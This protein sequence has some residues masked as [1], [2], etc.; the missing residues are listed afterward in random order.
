[1]KN[2][3]YY[4]S[5]DSFNKNSINPRMISQAFR[6]L[7]LKSPLWWG[8]ST[9]EKP[10]SPDIKLFKKN[11][12]VFSNTN[13]ISADEMTNDGKLP[14]QG[15]VKFTQQSPNTYAIHPISRASNLAPELTVDAYFLGYN[16]ANQSSVKPAY[17]DIPIQAAENSFLFTGSLTGCSVIVT[18]HDDTKYRVYHDGRVNSSVL[19][20]NVVMAF[21]FQD[22]QVAGTDEGL[23]MVYMRFNKD[24]WELVLQRQQYEVIDGIPT[25]QRRTQDESVILLYP[26]DA[27]YQSRLDKFN[28]YR[29]DIHQKLFN[30]AREMNIDTK[31]FKQGIYTDGDF[32]LDHQAILS[33][34][35]LRNKIKQYLNIERGKI[36]IK[37]KNARDELIEL[38][39]KKNKLPPT[40]EDGI[41][42]DELKSTIDLN[43]N[44]KE[45]YKQKYD[46]VLSGST[47]VE[48]SWLWLQIKNHHGNAA[49]VKLDE[50]SIKSGIQ[51]ESVR[52]RE[53]Y[54][55]ILNKDI[56][57]GKDDFK[58]GIKHYKE[59]SITGFDE[60]MS[61]SKMRELY[62][63]GG[64]RAKERGALSQYIQIKEQSEYIENILNYTL[65]TNSL[66]QDGGSIYQRFAPQDFYL[67]LIG[68]YEGGRCYP[69]VRAMSVALVQYDGVSGAN[70]LFNKL[71]IAAASPEE[72]SSII[73]RS[74]LQN[75]HFNTEAVGASS[76]IGL[77]NLKA[78]KKQLIESNGTQM[79][80]LNTQSHSM[81]I[82]KKVDNGEVR[83]CFYD[84]NFGLYI[85]DNPKK[86]S[87]CLDDFLVKEKMAFKYDALTE[88]SEPI[89]DFVSID[90]ELMANVDVGT[91]IRVEDL[92]SSTEL[93][94]VIPRRQKTRAFI[95]SQSVLAKDRQIKSSLSI[96]NA[97]QWGSRLESSLDKV[98][99]KYQLDEYWLPVF[100]STKRLEDGRYQIQFVHK[101]NEESSRWIETDDKTFF[102]FKEYFNE[103]IN[104]FSQHYTFKDL[105][106]QHEE[107]LGGGTETEHVD[108]LNSAIGIKALIEWAANRNRQS[109]ASGNP[110]NLDTALKIH[111]YVSYTM[112]AHGAVNDM[113]RVSRLVSVLWKEGSEVV[114][115]EMNSFTSSILHT[116]NEGIGA[117]FQGVMIGFDIYELANAE[118]EQQRTVI[119]TQLVF[120]SAAL[121]TSIVGYGASLLGAETVAG[122]AIPLAVP[123]TGLGIG[124]TELVN[125]NERHAQEAIEV[126]VIFGQYKEYYQNAAIYYNEEKKLLMPT[127]GIVIKEVNFLDANFKLG[128]EYIYRGE[129]RTWVFKH[130]TLSDFQ[131][132]PRADINKDKAINIR[133]GVGVLQDKV[134]FDPTKS[135]TIALPVIPQCYLRYE[136][137]S[138]FGGT[139]R[140]DYGFS[141]LRKMEEN[142]QFYFDYF[143]CGLE[144]V[145]SNLKAEYVFTPVLIVLDSTNKH[146]I[147]PTL[148]EPWHGYIEHSLIGAGAE[149]QISI[150]HGSSLKL[151]QSLLA[152][153]QSTWIIDTSSIDGQKGQVIKVND[154][155][156]QI[157]N[158]VVYIDETAASSKILIMNSE[159]EI[160][161]INFNNKTIDL[162][163]INGKHWGPKI[164]SIQHFLNDLANRNELKRKYVIVND[165]SVNGKNVG[166]AFYDVAARR[167][168]YTNS[169]NK[170][171]QS[172][173]LIAT[174]EDIAYFYSESENVI[175]SSNVNN[176]GVYAKFDFYDV[177]GDDSNIERISI[178]DNTVIVELTNRNRGSEVSVV[179][180]L[181]KNQLELVSISDDFRL[182][183]KLN[184]L[185]V[186]IPPRKHKDFLNHDY[187]VNEN[188]IRL[189]QDNKNT[190][191]TVASPTKPSPKLASIVMIKD[192]NYLGF[193][194]IYWLRTS[195]GVLI[196]P[197]LA[198][199]DDY[200]QKMIADMSQ[201]LHWFSTNSDELAYMNHRLANGE[202]FE[203]VL[204]LTYV[205]FTNKW[206]LSEIEGLFRVANTKPTLLK[207]VGACFNRF[208]PLTDTWN[209]K[210]PA[211]LILVGSLFD[212]NGGEVFFFYS[213]ESDTIFRQEG[214]GQ[215]D[216]DLKNPTAK[217]LSI[218]EIDTA[219]NWNGNILIIQKNGVVK[220]LNVNGSADIIAI[221]K[222]WFENE[223]FNWRNLNDFINEP[224]P[225][226]LFGLKGKDGTRVLPAWY[227][228][229]KVIVSESLPS[230]DTLHFLDFDSSEGCGIIFDIKTKKL[231]QQTAMSSAL[232]AD[233]FDD[234]QSLKPSEH[235]PKLI[236]LY[237]DV[238][239]ENVRKIGGGLMLSSSEGQLIFHPLSKNEPLGSSFII[240]G[241]NDDDILAPTQLKEAKTLI[242]SG[243][244]GKDT[245]HLKLEDWQNYRTIIIENQSQDQATDHLVLPISVKGSSIFINRFNDNLILTDSINQ[246]SLVLHNI[247]GANSLANQHLMIHFNDDIF[248]LSELANEV[249]VHRGALYLSSYLEQK[250][251]CNGDLA[252]LAD[253][254]SQITLTNNVSYQQHE[255]VG[256]NTSSS[257]IIPIN[258]LQPQIH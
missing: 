114:K 235:L 254:C 13:T 66:F 220:Q 93:S 129:K 165:Y 245:Y 116:A 72:K 133:E 159:H 193:Q 174:I 168:L 105:A 135:N 62:I 222:T 60:G 71:F 208:D 158:T 122:V 79:Y 14:P 8:T 107:H 233:M 176:G 210:P 164:D 241:T 125:I 178:K 246:T 224:N 2:D 17:I 179:Y 5:F 229:G 43:K 89:F 32:S 132:S 154:D 127:E 221:N 198:R 124:I 75:L 46:V 191:P 244:E 9:K 81:L 109:V 153:E 53:K 94:E 171:N 18:K 121:A 145:M 56:W 39:D 1:M 211:D 249:T 169:S 49:V 172:A 113:S 184:K 82:G 69:L 192:T 195:D 4:S 257:D 59:L 230:E 15:L 219:F 38:Q 139:S 34:V 142:D 58:Q 24:Q 91:G 151:K 101:G 100:A 157:G 170:E 120:D 183:E 143:Y 144:Y 199:P 104:S 110:S 7:K 77:L 74:S 148:P 134:T 90:I 86:F 173:I 16:G 247:Y 258:T 218:R 97:E 96:L 83:Y 186:T 25:P 73:L 36:D 155:N 140:G 102:E 87:K 35:E 130:S 187:L 205:G 40:E 250:P 149:Y 214:L 27:F 180:H 138:L 226:T 31:N 111:A 63:H 54:T 19:Y 141:V 196:K 103:S 30:L 161:E 115:T 51:S 162:V 136:Y 160:R 237:P 156:I 234:N 236:Q 213:K 131:S 242:L 194:C 190:L 177:L 216:I 150:N 167:M 41:R 61:T 182:M 166:R 55:V 197:N 3:F 256:L 163:S 251:Q 57:N 175:W 10:A 123:L 255:Q 225:I 106:L 98:T 146:L 37:I 209:W 84:P 215:K 147:V 239:L 112:M 50:S 108:G 238:S 85:F 80:A 119:G 227:F 126:G 47:S 29:S 52:N 21:D 240:K 26:D 20:D 231:Y 200:D 203:H 188:Y 228:K 185:D 118:N 253:S 78:I 117:I 88:K 232:L 64:L 252:Y 243:G 152:T 212:D 76:S 204:D 28:Q 201:T 128:S 12:I 22:Y 68:D 248:N 206:M 42:I 207:I 202:P 48:R 92:V 95:E 217:R 45:Y 11:T 189:S 23:A 6:D 99:Q 137:T 44:L 223:S 181:V 70:E 65:K 33:W 67:P